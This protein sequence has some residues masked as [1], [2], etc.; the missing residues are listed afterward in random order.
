MIP[1]IEELFKTYAEWI[2]WLRNKRAELETQRAKLKNQVVEPG[3]DPIAAVSAEP[4]GLDGAEAPPESVSRPEQ[5]ADDAGALSEPVPVLPQTE[6]E[7][8]PDWL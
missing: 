5:Q 7:D 4:Q 3:S 8:L 2:A 6:E 1:D